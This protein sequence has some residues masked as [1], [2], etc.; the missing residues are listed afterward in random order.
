MIDPA[1]FP[2]L[3]PVNH[4]VTSPAT[5]AY[6]CIAW[7]AHDTARW[8]QPGVY[9]PEPIDPFDCGLEVLRRAFR[10]LGYEDCPDGTLEAGYEKVALYGESALYTHAA[11]Q[12]PSGRWTSKLGACEDIEHDRP[13]DV[14]DGVYGPVCGFMRRAVSLGALVP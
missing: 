5:A 13:K 9:W 8:W 4:R 3:T 2:N 7:A 10:L 1:D 6:N 11:R 12:L 14:A